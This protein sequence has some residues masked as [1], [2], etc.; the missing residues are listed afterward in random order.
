V[1]VFYDQGN[2]FDET[3]T[4]PKRGAGIGLRWISPIG[5]IRLDLAS[6]LDNDNKLRLHLS[7]GPDL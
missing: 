2:A 1:A 3:N 5:P 6:A 4:D 7:M